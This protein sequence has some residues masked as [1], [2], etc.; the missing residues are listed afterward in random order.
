MASLTYWPAG[1]RKMMFAY[2]W[3][4]ARVEAGERQLARV[5][6]GVGEPSH[7]RLCVGATALIWSRRVADPELRGSG[8]LRGACA[9]DPAGCPLR[10]V[11]ERGDSF[12]PS[13]QPCALGGVELMD[14]WLPQPRECG[15][16]ESCV[17]RA[18]LPVVGLYAQEA[19]TDG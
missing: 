15:A 19:P 2:K 11:W 1:R 8:Y 12:V 13:T 16:C 9:T 7:E 6:D 3:N 5:L 17:A 18:S 14:G 10:I 4:D